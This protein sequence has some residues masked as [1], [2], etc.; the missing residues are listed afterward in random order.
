MNKVVKGCELRRASRRW[1]QIIRDSRKRR[2]RQR[3]RHDPV[4]DGVE[5]ADDVPKDNL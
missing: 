3:R 5:P 4:G 2:R 1:T